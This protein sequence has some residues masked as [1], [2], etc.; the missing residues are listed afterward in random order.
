MKSTVRSP[1]PYGN[2]CATC[3]RAKCR[4][5]PRRGGAA[6]VKGEGTNSVRRKT[7]NA[8]GWDFVGELI[9]MSSFEQGMPRSS[10]TSQDPAPYLVQVGSAVTENGWLDITVDVLF[11]RRSDGS[12]NSSSG[13][14]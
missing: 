9:L 8:V 2:A 1:L 3:A 14:K 5:I 11:L 6:A 12:A 7:I 13:A 10:G 4:C